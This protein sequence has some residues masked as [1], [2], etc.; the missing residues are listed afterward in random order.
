M[1]G[2]FFDHYKQPLKVKLI[3][4]ASIIFILTYVTIFKRFKSNLISFDLF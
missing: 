3:D 1:T 2:F 4:L